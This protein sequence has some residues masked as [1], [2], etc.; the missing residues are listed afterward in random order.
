MRVHRRSATF[1]FVIVVAGLSSAPIERNGVA[2]GDRVSAHETP[3]DVSRPP[4]LK[5]NWRFYLGMAALVLAVIMPLCAVL[6]PILGL[7]T[8]H[9]A[10][11][12]GILVAG[13]PEVLCS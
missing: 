7:A 3:G 5:R 11:L 6:V 2:E 4:T 8:T 12:V 1:L 13:G 10:V 9:S